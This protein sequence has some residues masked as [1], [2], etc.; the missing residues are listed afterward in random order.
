MSMDSIN[1]GPGGPA[2]FST[3]AGRSMVNQAMGAIR[4]PSPFFDIAH[5]YLPTSFKA[6]L[7][8]CRYYFLTNPLINSV[9]YKMAEYP[10]TDLIFDSDDVALIDK[11]RKFFDCT[12]QF[13]RFLV[14]A[15]LD[16]YCFGSSF[17]SIFYPFRKLLRCPSCKHTV[18]VERQ[19]YI[20]SSFKFVGD[21]QKCGDHVTFDA[22]DYYIKSPEEIRLIR[23]NPEYITIQH[24]D[25]TGDSEYFYAIPPADANDIR[26]GKKHVVEKVP[27]IFIDALREN[28]QL[29][30]GRGNLFHMKRPTI[31]QKD[32]GWGLPLIMPVLKDV[33]YLQILRKAQESISVEHI[34]PL[35]ILFPSTASASADPY[36][37]VN[38][39]AWRSR[40]EREL[41]R[42]RLDNNYIPIMPLPVGQQTLGGD[43][44]ALMLAQE[45]R[46][47][48]EHIVSGMGVPVEF[49]FGGMSYSGSSVSMRMLENHFIE[50][51]SNHHKLVE[52]FIMP[53][54]SAYMGWE[55]IKS[56]F[57]KFKMAD[58]L[59][60]SAFNLQLVQA[61][62][63][64]D[65][66]LLEE[67]DWDAKGEADRIA[68]EQKRVIE[69]Q[70]QTSIAQAI[71]Q[72]ESQLVM[73]KYQAKAQ[74]MMAELMG[75][76]QMPMPGQGQ[77][78]QGAPAGQGQLPQ[79]APAGQ[80]Q[81]PGAAP[82]GQE[83]QPG[84][85]PP[86]PMGSMG[87]PLNA[88]QQGPGPLAMQNMDI[89]NIAEKIAAFLDQLPDA[90]KVARLQL[91]AKNN[92]QLHAI[93]MQLLEQRAG[94]H[95][96]SSKKAQPE[97]KPARRGAE[98]QM[99]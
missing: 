28:K 59:Q 36:Q 10:V 5:M 12:L 82:T 98:A 17:I 2:R 95:Q 60:R 11:W 20:F 77:P 13:K 39:T 52:N 71:I 50:D 58:D 63:L 34:V 67:I 87:S 32:R 53:N 86:A 3:T 62:K 40:M 93:V 24:S 80:E 83:Q 69:N 30:F 42:W 56:H 38:L 4:Y 19:K 79:G 90:D 72:G 21:C 44:R 92:A 22:F 25:A 97:Q 64:S 51:R 23:W 85:A 73:Q 33:F 65:H 74:K 46:V 91:L 41:M 94:A 68:E 88:D 37:S 89:M 84:A 96:P 78:S 1:F 48:S 76:A 99:I 6:L 57:R 31:A 61:N 8:W 54:V 47:W 7:K 49:A 18:A 35:R 45:Y 75:P 14:E 66:T 81:Q 55:P 16:Y 27:Q 9:V 43:G 29:K 15:G 26:M 70:R